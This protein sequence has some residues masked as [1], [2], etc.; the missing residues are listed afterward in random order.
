MAFNVVVLRSA[1]HDLQEI[2]DY[3][4]NTFSQERWSQTSNLLKSS[5][6]NLGTLPWAGSIPEEIE[7]LNLSQYRQVVCGMNRIIYEVRQESVYIHAVI[8]VR[9]DMTSFLTKRLLRFIQE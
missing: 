6:V 3:L 8:D 1:K 5:M 2:R 7:K 9:R 4:V